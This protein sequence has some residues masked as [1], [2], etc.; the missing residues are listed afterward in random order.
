ML[1]LSKSH[2]PFTAALGNRLNIKNR[3]ILGSLGLVQ[4]RFRIFSFSF[5][6]GEILFL[7]TP[8]V[9]GCKVRFLRRT[10]LEGSYLLHRGRGSGLPACECPYQE[11]E[12]A[13]LFLSGLTDKE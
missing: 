13:F 4:N 3:N 1:Y 9:T 12:V 5:L 2:W 7:Q 6:L 8:A 11:Y 10:N